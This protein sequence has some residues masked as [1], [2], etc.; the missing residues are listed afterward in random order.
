MTSRRTIDAPL[1][2]PAF[3]VAK[4]VADGFADAIEGW[5]GSAAAHVSAVSV[6]AQEC[7]GHTDAASGFAFIDKLLHGDTPS[8]D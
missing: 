7:D 3:E 2:E 8:H 5:S 1:S 6:C 4:V